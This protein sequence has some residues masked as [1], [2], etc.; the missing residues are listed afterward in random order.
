VELIE[1]KVEK[2]RMK[3]YYMT[4]PLTYSK[5]ITPLCEILA[6]GSIRARFMALSWIRAACLQHVER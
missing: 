1:K 4:S 3:E 2:I 5:N 6:G